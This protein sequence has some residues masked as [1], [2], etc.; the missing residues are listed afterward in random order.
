[1]LVYQVSVKCPINIMRGGVSAP[2]LGPTPYPYAYADTQP[3]PLI[4]I[5]VHR[6]HRV[7]LSGYAH[8]CKAGLRP[9]P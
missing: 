4:Y 2:P 7:H 1:M 9:P 8:S 6:L 3:R 5:H